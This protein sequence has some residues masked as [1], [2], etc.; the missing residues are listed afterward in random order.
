[1]ADYDPDI[2]QH[3]ADRLYARANAAMLLYAS[4]GFIVGGLVGALVAMRSDDGAVLILVFG[5]LSAIVG[6][7]KA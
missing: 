4:C 6:S 5:G 1:M 3:Y 7:V 2:L